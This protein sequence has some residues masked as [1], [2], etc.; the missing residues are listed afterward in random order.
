[1]WKIYEQLS[2]QMHL[3]SMFLSG[4]LYIYKMSLA[5]RAIDDS[6]LKCL[7]TQG[8]RGGGGGG[9]FNMKTEISVQINYRKNLKKLHKHCISA[10]A[11]F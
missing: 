5:K 1:M 3:A 4:F 10:Y 8:L 11:T 7:D 9:A 2:K 6:T